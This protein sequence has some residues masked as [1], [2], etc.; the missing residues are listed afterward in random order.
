MILK[1]ALCSIIMGIL[2]YAS[3]GLLR[4]AIGS[5]FAVIA[6]IAVGGAVYCAALLL[7]GTLNKEEMRSLLRRRQK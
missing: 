1:P 7:T 6:A 2:A 3:Y 5:N 4:S